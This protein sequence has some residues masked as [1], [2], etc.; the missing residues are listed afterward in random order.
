MDP[1]KQYFGLLAN[2][3]DHK[4]DSAY[5]IHTIV[6]AKGGGDEEHAR[7]ILN[8]YLNSLKDPV[9]KYTVELINPYIVSE[10]DKGFA[11]YLGNAPQID[12]LMDNKSYAERTLSGVIFKE[13]LLPLIETNKD[14]FGNW[15]KIL[16]SIEKKYHALNKGSLELW[17]GQYF[18]SEINQEILEQVK[19]KDDTLRAADWSTIHRKLLKRFAGYD[20]GHLFVDV[21]IRYF[22]DRKMWEECATAAFAVIN[23]YGKNFKPATT[24]DMIWKLIFMHSEDAKILKKSTIM[25]AKLVKIAPNDVDDLDT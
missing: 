20:C 11:I 6:A 19:S 23:Q 9:T 18:Q 16:E 24:N 17:L 25:M 14:S 22:F 3:E 15:K 8:D 5:L 21:Q 10:E 12:R 2:W 7:T 4:S 13:E 1:H